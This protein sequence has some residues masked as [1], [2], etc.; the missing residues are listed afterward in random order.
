M[1]SIRFKIVAISVGGILTAIM[2]VFLASYY[3]IHAEI[4]QRSAESLNLIGQDTKKTLELYLDGITRS[5]EMAGRIASDSLD[6]MMLAEQGIVG[7][8]P[9]KSS[10]T[11]EQQAVIDSYLARYTA[12]V[13]D[14]A[15][16]IANHTDGVITYY[17]CIS[18]DISTKEHG[19][20]YSRVGKT[21]FEEREPLDAREFDE[22]DPEHYMWYYAPIH[23]GR[24]SWVGPYTAHFLD[25]MRICSYLVP[26]YKA[27]AF[28]GVLGMDIPVDTLV[29]QVS[30]IKVYDTGFAC[31]LDEDGKVLY[32]PELL[33]GSTPELSTGLSFLQQQDSGDEPIRY[34]YGGQERQL[35]FTTLSNGMK[36]VIVVPISEVN[37]SAIRLSRIILAITIAV[38]SAFCLLVL[39]L[40]RYITNPLLRLTA[41]SRQLA[42]GEYDVALD[43]HADD[44]VGALTE[45]FSSMRGQ[46]QKDIE[47]LN[48]KV[49]TD[50]LTGLPNQR[51]FFELCDEER[52]R[53]S[54]EGREAVVLYFDLV[55]MKHFN[56]QY[57]FDEGDRL[58]CAVA[59]ILAGQ[60]GA[61]RTSR[62]GQDQ[63]A[64]IAA[65]EG[66]EDAMEEVFRQRQ[67]VNGGKTLPLRVGVYPFSLEDV[68]SSVACDRAKF[69]CDQQRGTYVTGY[70]CF[71][72]TMLRQVSTVRHVINNLDRALEERWVQVYYQPIVQASTGRV[73]DQEAL[74]R[75]VDPQRGL[76]N[77]AD[78]IP[79]L[80][81]AGLIYKID[82][83]VLDRVL[84]KILEQRELGLPDVPHSINLS[85][86]DFDSCDMVEEIRKRVDA[87]GVKRSA[88]SIEITESIIGSDFD[89]MK[90]EVARFRSLG[91]PVWMDD[92]GSGYSSL[93]VLQ[94]IEF[95][96]LKFDMSFLRK[97]DEGERGKVILA[98][99]MRMAS[100]LGVDT[101][102]EGVETEEQYKF[103]KSIGCSKLQGYYFG[104]PVTKEQ[105][106]ERLRV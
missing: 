46:L 3:T 106:L 14:E 16:T 73:C 47:D 103:L 40:A 94:S 26:I 37:A 49:L 35:S 55:D 17:Y 54:L 30:S 18:P 102:C 99:L 7:S 33:P 8:N 9:Q 84:E 82:L 74:S 41:A 72:A 4:D 42:A 1:H 79:A 97:F 89:F 12:A 98:D 61:E 76:L 13:R 56:Q 32:H 100:A 51:Y 83:Y 104:R 64:V 5:T 105:I 11:S 50:A 2:C 36:L 52:R 43:Y 66:M 75:W 25:E 6:G 19:F 23:R 93:D 45:S 63:F 85:R 65:R 29:S 87:A 15:E 24:P 48:R 58:I 67:A 34:T 38:V 44:E 101:I 62:F 96:L 53:L 60:F 68:S 91:F 57:G 77:P 20:F 88:L 59:D 10:R 71:D 81:N 90:G 22:H 39:L 21:G 95:D 70:R 92:F 31:L 69:A 86:S 27:G 28:I 80:E 78:F